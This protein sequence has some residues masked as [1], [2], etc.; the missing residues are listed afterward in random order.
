MKHLLTLLATC[1]V[2]T[3][4]ASGIAFASA[5]SFRDDFDSFDET[6]WERGDHNLGR[7]YLD[8]AN[9]EVSNGTLNLKLPA[10][11]TD[12]AELMSDDLHGYGSYTARIK[13]P[14]APSS[15]TGFFLYAPP[16]FESEVDIEIFNDRSRKVMFTS[17]NNGRKVTETKRLPFDPTKG[18]HDYRFDHGPKHVDFYVDG[19]RMHRISGNSPDDPMRL[20]V[21]AWYPN[22]LAGK[23][24]GKNKLVRVDWIRHIQ[25]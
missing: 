16:D 20:Y 1:A 25:R 14:R 6:R 3:L 15:I 10:R 5:A 4:L 21:N 2:A 13:L 23:Q 9:L 11:T 19:R 24:S 12:G 18:F 22:W 8:P 7:S 17:Y